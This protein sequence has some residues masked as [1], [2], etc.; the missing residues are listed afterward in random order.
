MS[1]PFHYS[2]LT[3]DLAQSSPASSLNIFWNQL[4]EKRKADSIMYFT[5]NFDPTIGYQYPEFGTWG[6]NLLNPMLAIQ[7]TMQSFQNGNW[8]NGMNG[9]GNWFNNMPWSNWWNNNNNSNDD[10][11]GGNSSSNSYDYDSLKTLITKYRDLY[12]DSMSG[13]LKERIN[14]ALNK[15]GKADEKMGALKEVYK[16]LD[17]TKLEN[18]ILELPEYY[19]SLTTA[20]YKFA[21]PKKGDS[22]TAMLKDIKDLNSAESEI[23]G[24]H[25]DRLLQI[26][27]SESEP[28]ILKVISMWNDKFHDDTN[29]S[30]IRLLA[31][32]IPDK[33]E[34]KTNFIDVVKYLCMSL[35]NKVE[36]FKAGVDGDFPKLDKAAAELSDALEKAT[37]SA[38]NFNGTNVEAIAPKFEKLY[39][40]LRMMEAEK[41]RNTI[42][43]KYSFLND[44]SQNDR[45]FVNSDL[46]VK[47]TKA[48]L[49]A[50]GITVNETGLDDVPEEKIDD[51]E[52]EITDIDEKCE[53][54]DE[55]IEKLIEKDKL[56]KT[57]KE[58]VYKSKA[59]ST[60]ES[61]K[62]YTIKDEK[63]VELK[64]VKSVD[65]DGK[66]K[67]ID[68][69]A[70][71]TVD[72]VETAEVTAQDIVDYNS[73]LDN[74][75]TLTK[76][77]TIVKCPTDLSKTS[78]PKGLTLY[79][80]KGL[81][82]DGH[83]QCF[84]IRNNKLM[85]INGYVQGNGTVKLADGSVKKYDELTDDDF[86]D[87]NSSD[88]VTEDLKAKAEQ[89]K[90]D[91]AKAK[92]D[93]E[94]E[95]A[96]ADAEA[97]EAMF[98]KKYEAPEQEDYGIDIGRNIAK[99]LMGNTNDDEWI[100][101]KSDIKKITAD[102]VHDVISAFA[103]EEG[104]GTD[105]ILEQIATEQEA[106]GWFGSEWGQEKRSE[107]ERL[108]LIKHII[109]AVL[110]H[111]EKYGIK[112]RSSYEKLEEAYKNITV[113]DI[114][115][116][117]TTKIRELD[118]YILKLVKHD[119][120]ETSN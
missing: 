96:N 66:C 18:A 27:G 107:T 83:K 21:V 86:L 63:L 17:K 16:S 37:K 117:A 25:V 4:N 87:I 5:P 43:S 48:D 60:N 51:V 46:I 85:E 109:K 9:S 84:V 57:D 103:A 105:N 2:Y 79:W 94:V 23:R 81:K 8:M 50:E 108:N 40:M 3:Y 42:K 74:I 78:W 67:M 118:R 65:K 89:E 93:K 119:V 80:S 76:D 75:T 22:R 114:N 55:K 6:N 120:K 24:G 110:D 88:I 91:A 71:K 111:C 26:V 98:D 72:T 92:S 13:E 38:S 36:D 12:S 47:S 44:I 7:Q 19:E 34:E 31:K 1:F 29:R 39:A 99:N 20:G 95:E 53:T 82:E 106:T 77:D 52:D 101:A 100:D 116:K 113:D 28:E 14:K 70:D 15:S 68:G 73:T 41:I 62:F 102:N 90:R 64:G 104:M 35:K 49:K 115:N 56:T 97:R 32:H 33:D 30:I 54:A 61:P 69:S 59:T 11:N 45:D 10:G 58:G 112:S